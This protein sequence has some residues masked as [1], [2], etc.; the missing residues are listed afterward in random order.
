M[1]TSPAH[2]NANAFKAKRALEPN[3]ALPVF[4][5]LKNTFYKCTFIID[6]IARNTNCEL[7]LSGI[8]PLLIANELYSYQYMYI[9][10]LLSII[11]F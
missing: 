4:I 3:V 5:W 11:I 9:T 6:L 1:E 7:Q 8:Y 2:L 10:K